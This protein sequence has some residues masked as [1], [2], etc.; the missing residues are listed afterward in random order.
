MYKSEI[1]CLHVCLSVCLVVMVDPESHT[2]PQLAW[3]W[4]REVVVGLGLV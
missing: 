2:L 1:L 4:G 3:G